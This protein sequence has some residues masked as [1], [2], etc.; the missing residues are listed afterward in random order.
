MVL[1]GILYIVG[2]ALT[3]GTLLVRSALII[4]AVVVA[5]LAFAGGAARI[6]STWVRRWIQVTLALIL[7]KLAIVH[8]VR[9]R[10]GPRRRRDRHR[11]GPVRD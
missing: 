3:L 2:A 5:P 11:R 8:R 7:S 9:H 6:T 4:V 10:R 1:F